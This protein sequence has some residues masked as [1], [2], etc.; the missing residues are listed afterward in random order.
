MQSFSHTYIH[1]YQYNHTYIG[2]YMYTCTQTNIQVWVCKACATRFNEGTRGVFEYRDKKDQERR[3]KQ[4]KTK[5]R[6]L[7]D[8]QVCM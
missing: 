5:I 4:I 6:L 2:T 8:L 3:E 7:Q 1:M